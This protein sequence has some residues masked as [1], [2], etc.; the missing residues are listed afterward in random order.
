M[1]AFSDGKVMSISLTNF[2]GSKSMK[3]HFG[4][5]SNIITGPNGSGKSTLLYAIMVLFGADKEIWAQ[6]F[7]SIAGFVNTQANSAI[8]EAEV[9]H[10]HTR[11]RYKKE[12]FRIRVI[13]QRIPS[14]KVE[15]SINGKKVSK[16][17]ATA[18][19][20]RLNIRTDNM[21]CVMPQE[22]ANRI[23]AERPST[24]LQI[25]MEGIADKT[26]QHS[27][28][29]MKKM[30]SI[31]LKS[32]DFRTTHSTDLET[33]KKELQVAK[34]HYDLKKEI[35]Q[36]IAFH[37]LL[38][39][40]T[41]WQRVLLKAVQWRKV[42]KKREDLRES[43]SHLAGLIGDIESEQKA[44]SVQRNKLRMK[45]K[46]AE[47]LCQQYLTEYHD[48]CGVVKDRNDHLVH[49]T[50]R[51][52]RTRR[53]LDEMA[54]QSDQFS[55]TL[56]KLQKEQTEEEYNAP[57]LKDAL[58][59]VSDQLKTARTAVAEA[60]DDKFRVIQESKHIQKRFTQLMN[61]LTKRTKGIAKIR[62]RIPNFARICETL[63]PALNESGIKG[64]GKIFGRRD[65]WNR[66]PYGPL[67]YHFGLEEDDKLPGYLHNHPRR[68]STILCQFI[69]QLKMFEF[70]CLTSEDNIRFSRVLK[71]S[72]LRIN[73]FSIGHRS[74]RYRKS[75]L[76]QRAI[77]GGVLCCIGDLLQGEPFCLDVM[78]SAFL[79]YMAVPVMKEE[80]TD[81]SSTVEFIKS[82]TI[83]DI[84]SEGHLMV[85]GE[86]ETV[87]G[88][89][90][91]RGKREECLN[92]FS[93]P[94]KGCILK[95]CMF[96]LK[97]YGVS[98]T[99]VD[100]LNET[101]MRRLSGY[102][103]NEQKSLS[104]FL[105]NRDLYPLDIGEDTS[106][107]GTRVKPTCE[108]Y[109]R[110]PREDEDEEED[111]LFGFDGDEMEPRTSRTQQRTASSSSDSV[112]WKYLDLFNK[113]IKPFEN[114]QSK[115][116]EK[117][118]V[119]VQCQEEVERI[120]R[121]W[122]SAKE[123]LAKHRHT[124]DQLSYDITRLEFK[125]TEFQRD[126]IECQERISD[127]DEQ[128]KR[129]IVNLKQSLSQVMAYDLKNIS[130]ATIKAVSLE[131]DVQILS[132]KLQELKESLDQHKKEYVEAERRSGNI[133][134]QEQEA[135][136]EL[137]KRI[138]IASAECSMID[139]LVSLEVI[140]FS[141]LRHAFT[142]DAQERQSRS[143]TLALT[144]SQ[145]T[146][147]ARSSQLTSSDMW[148]RT[149]KSV[150]SLKEELIAIEKLLFAHGRLK[151]KV[152][153]SESKEGE[154]MREGKGETKEESKKKEEEEEREEEEEFED[155]MDEEEI[156]KKHRIH[157]VF[158]TKHVPL[159]TCQVASLLS[160]PEPTFSH[161]KLTTLEDLTDDVLK[162]RE[163]KSRGYDPYLANG[164]KELKRSV[165]KLEAQVK[166]AESEELD[167]LGKIVKV[168]NKWIS[169]MNNVIEIVNSIF[170]SLL[171]K[172][173][174]TGLIALE[175][176]YGDKRDLID[177]K[178][179]DDLQ[180]IQTRHSLREMFDFGR[181]GLSMRSS[182]RKGH[183]VTRGTRS[184]GENSA[185]S[186]SFVTSLKGVTG[187]PFRVVDEIN[188]GMD[189]KNE[190]CAHRVLVD[191]EGIVD[192]SVLKRGETLIKRA[193]KKAELRERK[194]LELRRKNK[195]KKRKDEEEEDQEDDLFAGLDEEEEEEEDDEEEEEE[196][197]E[198]GEEA[199]SPFEG[200][201]HLIATPKL[202]NGLYFPSSLRAHV[203]CTKPVFTHSNHISGSRYLQGG[204]KVVKSGFSLKKYMSDETYDAIKA[205]F[206]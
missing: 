51:L 53:K 81:N 45:L 101:H 159:E 102:I 153:I 10:R 66:L 37:A 18:L 152:L 88:I 72:D 105:C 90:I 22:K 2:M 169:D 7:K 137:M 135:R 83:G 91:G 145:R 183:D 206:K 195:R 78:C 16:K 65:E 119:E 21:C 14:L 168:R 157:Y 185:L 194:K 58:E 17:S 64:T 28:F 201:Q 175:A 82:L 70:V 127:Y 59:V 31:Y 4:P 89:R 131:R 192:K 166:A 189:S 108:D 74:I 187:F 181:Y 174:G 67:L 52:Q 34:R 79:E 113:L 196:E 188:Q 141:D 76:S 172:F 132:A 41:P 171:Q 68:A 151:R 182:F 47:D 20:R 103:A 40:A 23:A 42:H 39:K 134:E 93:R 164:Y 142:T 33:K 129:S 150:D 133:V 3:Y 204:Y 126:R 147:D 130:N 128:R 184:G 26:P 114:A 80:V 15:Y 122:D 32:R 99:T 139:A 178:P 167:K 148:T 85:I 9:Y 97:K 191:M 144:T 197:E 92:M 118:D 140:A 109:E 177:F 117:R 121:Q 98:R 106:Y 12:S 190:R 29:R 205:Q 44:T 203:I 104:Q 125:I 8:I 193:K 94:V 111:M 46:D 110:E 136:N 170:N 73:S 11:G 49:I 115:E 27:F 146:T 1:D 154:E 24:L 116:K 19:C 199:E 77:R 43:L 202:P 149:G 71:R 55:L 138:S 173:R 25:F 13:I 84:Y 155:V 112:P 200:T 38:V 54:V 30:Y 143:P 87:D 86:D 198:E 165:D 60:R 107:S 5:S 124:L 180:E 69:N 100:V 61:S 48:I 56:E 120:K 186:L 57:R 160:L 75:S 179:G 96:N 163:G 35:E 162:Q 176:P 50:A 6:K 62:V 36:L 158:T 156:E 95:E 63:I 123:Q 161:L